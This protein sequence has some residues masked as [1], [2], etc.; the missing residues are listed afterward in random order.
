MSRTVT[1]RSL[2]AIGTHQT[3]TGTDDH[4]YLDDALDA[5]HRRCTGNRD[6]PRTFA[7]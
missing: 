2:H 1:P 3:L 5:G 7:D 6:T 4:N